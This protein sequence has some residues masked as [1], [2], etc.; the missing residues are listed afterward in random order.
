M[1]YHLLRKGN[2]LPYDQKMRVLDWCQSAFEAGVRGDIIAHR[3]KFNMNFFSDKVCGRK[4]PGLYTRIKKINTVDAYKIRRY[5]SAQYKV[6]Q[7]VY[8]HDVLVGRG[9]KYVEKV[10]PK[11]DS[12][13]LV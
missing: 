11:L 2:K 12:I 4:T 3:D 10:D 9:V 7:K 13:V 6:F 5:M 8:D 1:P